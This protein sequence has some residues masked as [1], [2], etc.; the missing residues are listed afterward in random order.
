MT[1]QVP[2]RMSQ[3]GG[4]VTTPALPG[5][6]VCLVSGASSVLTSGP[7]PQ[8]GLCTVGLNFPSLWGG[9]GGRVPSVYMGQN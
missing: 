3:A 9:G 4:M 7:S 8:S 1:S 6:A 2:S 5:L